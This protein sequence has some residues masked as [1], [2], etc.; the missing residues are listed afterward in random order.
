MKKKKRGREGI[1]RIE[2][3]EGLHYEMK[4]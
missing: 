2:E 3:E 4:G 1:E